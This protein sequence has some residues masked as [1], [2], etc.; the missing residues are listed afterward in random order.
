MASRRMIKM[1][2]LLLSII[3]FLQLGA[4]GAS[5]VSASSPATQSD[6]PAASA[7]DAVSDSTEAQPKDILPKLEKAYNDQDMNAIVE[8]FD[9]SIQSATIGFLELFGL[10]GEAMKQIMPFFSQVLGASGLLDNGQWGTVRLEEI[11]TQIDGTDATLVYSVNLSYSDGTTQ[12]IEDTVQT[13]LIDGTWYIAAIQIPSVD[14]AGGVTGVL[15]ELYDGELY[16]TGGGFDKI[17]FADEDGNLII[18]QQYA[19]VRSFVNGYCAV[20]NGEAWGIIDKANRLVIPYQYQACGDYADGV[21]PVKKQGYWGC[22]DESNETVVDFTYDVMQSCSAYNRIAVEINGARGV[23]DTTGAYIIP[24]SSDMGKVILITDS[25]IV[26]ETGSS[27]Y[28]SLYALYDINGKYLRDVSNPAA[29]GDGLLYVQLIDPD[30]LE[31]A[32]ILDKTGNELFDL[33]ALLKADVKAKFNGAELI[34]RNYYSTTNFISGWAFSDKN[35]VIESGTWLLIRIPAFDYNMSVSYYY[36]FINIQ[37]KILLDAWLPDIF[38]NKVS[39]EGYIMEIYGPRYSNDSRK[40]MICS[41]DGKIIYNE[42]CDGSADFFGREK[43]L[44]QTSDGYAI[45]DLITGDTQAYKE[46]KL[47]GPNAVYVSDGI[48]WGLNIDGVLVY[49]IEYTEISYNAETRVYTLEKGA[50]QTQIRISDSGEIIE[51]DY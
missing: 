23:I 3:L 32:A 5:N 33:T 6:A 14:P 10:K 48:F 11:S 19:N 20:S 41:N 44:V 21:F 29:Y 40:V 4:C 12:Q 15:P 31:H 47:A 50:D 28:T 39:S 34:S 36:N 25:F 18:S 30:G 16:V 17:G 24:L 37:G 9:P 27:Y 1:M 42:I 13:V 49:N 43:A 38:E 45:V 7:Q 8:C 51:L 35:S 2:V 22:V 46:A 26:S